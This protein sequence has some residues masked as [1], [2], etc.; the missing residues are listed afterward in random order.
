MTYQSRFEWAVSVIDTAPENNILEIGCG[1]G[2]LAEL[3]TAKLTS[4]KLTGIDSS[5]AMIRMAEKRNAAAIDAGKSNFI[6]TPFL[7]ADLPVA[8]FD[9]IVAFNVNFFWKS[10]EQ[11][12][13]RISKLLKPSGRLFVFYQTPSGVDKKLLNK[14][15]AELLAN[16]FEII[17]AIVE[18]PKPVASFCLV[19]SPAQ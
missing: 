9:S 11:E 7:K 18:V 14:I 17:S 3:L 6:T 8:A 16:G 2:L 15:R 1:A 19:S 13:L 12:M 10:P 4:G 5:A